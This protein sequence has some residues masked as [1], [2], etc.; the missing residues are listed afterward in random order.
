[1]SPGQITGQR[2]PDDDSPDDD[3]PLAGGE[4][5]GARLAA[6]DPRQLG[7]RPLRPEL[8]G[9]LPEDGQRLV[10]GKLFGTGPTES[11]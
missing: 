8:R 5:V 2:F 1:M 11:G 9:T 4:L 6:P 10:Q 7:A 3:P